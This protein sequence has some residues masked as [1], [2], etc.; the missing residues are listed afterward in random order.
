MALASRRVVG[1]KQPRSEHLMVLI[2]D[3][4]IILVRDLVVRLLAIAVGV[5]QE[6]RDLPTRILLHLIVMVHVDGNDVRQ[7]ALPDLRS[8]IEARLAL[9]KTLP[10]LREDLDHPIRGVRTVKRTG[11][12]SLDHLDSFNVF[13]VQI[14]EAKA[15]DRAIDDDERIL[16]TR[17]TRRGSQANRWL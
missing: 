8:E 12:G 1:E 14:G 11:G 17:Q 15:G 16:S 13:R 4:G 5:E 10:A 6:A 9:G 7:R 3:D 2:V